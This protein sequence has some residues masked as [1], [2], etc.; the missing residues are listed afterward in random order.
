VLLPVLLLRY[1]DRARAREAD[2]ERRIGRLARHRH[3]ALAGL[4]HRVEIHEVV[5][6]AGGGLRID[7]ALDAEDH[8]LRGHGIAVLEAGVFAEGEDVCRVVGR[9]PGLGECGDDLTVGILAD[10]AL[11]HRRGEV[12]V[13]D[14]A[15]LADV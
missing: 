3:L 8:V 6:G 5:V 2:E 1:H 10:E 7:R 9:L 11:L 12:V 15:L 13:E 14:A 4:L